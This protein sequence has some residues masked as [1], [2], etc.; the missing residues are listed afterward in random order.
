MND[1]KNLTLGISLI[2]LIALSGTTQAQQNQYIK[3]NNSI[4]WDN[5]CDMRGGQ[6]YGGQRYGGWQKRNFD[7]MQ[8]GFT[9]MTQEELINHRDKIFS[10]KNYNECKSIQ[11]NQHKNMLDRAKAQG[12]TLPETPRYNMC[13]RLNDRGYFK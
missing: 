2:F 7:R 9:L 4:R 11:T 1:F 8:G 3:N 13:D 5:C 10:A 6:F 12:V